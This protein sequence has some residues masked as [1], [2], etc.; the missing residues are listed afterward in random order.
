MVNVSAY[1]ER[2]N[3]HLERLEVTSR[4]HPDAYVDAFNN[5]IPARRMAESYQRRLHKEQKPAEQ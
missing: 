3:F 2:V 1:V 5:Q 4:P